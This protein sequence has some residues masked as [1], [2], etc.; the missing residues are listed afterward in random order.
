MKN[1][2][3]VQHGFAEVIVAPTPNN[4]QNLSDSLLATLLSNMAYYGYCP[5]KALLEKLMQCSKDEAV[6]FWNEL[7]PALIYEKATD[8]DM[9]AHVV[10][11]NFPQEVLD[12]SEYQYWYNQFFIYL[13][14][15]NIVNKEPAKP[16][17]KSLELKELRLLAPANESTLQD[18]LNTNIGLTSSWTGVQFEQTRFLFEH[19]AKDTLDFD[20]FGFKMNAVNLASV[21][22]KEGNVKLII[23]DATNVIRLATVLSGYEDGRVSPKVRFKGFSRTQRKLFLELLEKSKNLEADITLNKKVWKGFLHGLHPSDYGYQRVIKAQ[24]ELYNNRVTSF[25]GKIDRILKEAFPEY[26]ASKNVAVEVEDLPPVQLA[27]ILDEKTRKAL[28]EIRAKSLRAEEKVKEE[29]PKKLNKRAVFDILVPLLRSRP[30]EFMRQYHML[31]E[32]FGDMVTSQLSTVLYKIEPIKLLKFKKYLNTINGRKSLIYAP[33]SNWTK[34]SFVE[35]NKVKLSKESIRLL[36]NEISLIINS[37][38]ENSLPSGIQLDEKLK[39][40]KLQT[41]AQELA[42]YGRGTRFEIPENITFIRSGSYWQTDEYYDTWYDNGWNFFDSKWEPLATC[43]WNSERVLDDSA[44]FS[45]DPATGGTAEGKGCQMID[46]YLEQLIEKGVR[47]ALWNVLG[48]SHKTFS[49]AD[50]VATLQMGENPS[51][52]KIYEP[53]RA[54]MV[55]PLKG[56]NLTKYIL[57]LDLKTR[58]VVYLDANLYAC[59]DSAESNEGIMSERMPQF[60][61]YINSLPSIYDLLENVEE[62]DVPFLYDDKTEAVL[63]KR[64]YVFNKQNTGSEFDSIDINS[65]LETS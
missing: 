36:S 64:A 8:R 44:I 15:E 30:S 40:V 55:F 19:L 31:Y 51:E 57:L 13:G 47:Y 24:D 46:L 9:N 63:S 26:F 28:E 5:T 23:Q 21:L 27:D 49:E 58:E 32:L 22:Y 52:D 17:R 43:C 18:I 25:Q 65:L 62:G 14:F 60:M 38:L 59:V 34:S 10:Y 48:F 16:R 2:T 33:N 45:G 12:M 11:K 42:P 37:H 54:S 1:I 50:V 56:N 3:L 35:N 39:K 6:L 61:E 4:T 41:N 20:S 29:K 7:E 53:S